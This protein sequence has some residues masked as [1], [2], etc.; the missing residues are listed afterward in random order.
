ML[1][2]GDAH[3]VATVRNL[4]L[5]GYVGFHR[6]HPESEALAAGLR[7]DKAPPEGYRPVAA[8]AGVLLIAATPALAAA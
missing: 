1:V 7:A 8:D 6:V 2:A 5:A 3:R 4:A